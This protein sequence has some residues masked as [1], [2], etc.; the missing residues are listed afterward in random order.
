M[1][2]PPPKV[3][4]TPSASPTPV[5]GSSSF[6]PTP[7]RIADVA[8]PLKR[9]CYASTSRQSR[10]SSSATPDDF[11]TEREA[12][13][14]RMLD[15][16]S[17]LA[18]KY[19]RRI[20]EDDIVDLVTGEIVKDR[21]VLSG[22]T[23]WK[24]GRFADLDD[25][26]G[27]DEEDEDDVDELD[28][29]A[30]SGTTEDPPVHVQ[31][32][33][34][35]PPVRKMDPAD[36]KDLEEFMEAE[37][38]RREEC[39]DDEVSEDGGDLDEQRHAEALFDNGD[40]SDEKDSPFLVKEKASASRSAPPVPHAEVDESDDELGNWDVLDASNIVYV[41]EKTGD[42]QEII[43]ILDTPPPARSPRGKSS[44]PKSKS[45]AP[46]SSKTIG[47]SR[48]HPQ[49]QLQTPPQ[50]R[51]PPSVLPSADDY[52]IP[53]P[54]ASPPSSPTSS[55]YDLYPS[56]PTKPKSKVD[57]DTRTQTRSQSR[58]R[59]SHP[60]SNEPTTSRDEKVVPKLDLANL[61]RGR[62]TTK[63]T[64]RPGLAGSSGAKANGVGKPKTPIVQPAVKQDLEGGG[65][66]KPKANLAS[67]SKQPKASRDA[68][69]R[70]AVRKSPSAL[71]PRQDVDSAYPDPKSRVA[72]TK[73][74]DKHKMEDTAP[75]ARNIKGKCRA[76]DL[77]YDL[78]DDDHWREESNDPIESFA[79]TSLSR[80]EKGQ[81]ASSSFSDSPSKQ[82]S[83]SRRGL[84]LEQQSS[85][86]SPDAVP[87]ST[88][89]RKRRSLSSDN[90]LLME[91]KSSTG[92]THD[93]RPSSSSA[94]RQPEHGQL[95]PPL[96]PKSNLKSRSRTTGSGYESNSNP[97]SEQEL[98]LHRA[99]SR[100]CADLETTAVPVYYPP[101]GPYYPY[102]PYLSSPSQYGADAHGVTPL[103]DPRAQIIISQAMHQAM[104]QLSTLFTAPWMAG[105]PYTP[106]RH[107]SSSRPAPAPGS[108]PYS[109]PTTPH[110]P[111]AYPYI[112]D[113][114]V[115]TGTLPPSSPP[116]SSPPSLASS[117][118]HV[119]SA[120]QTLG[121]RASLVPRS[122][123]RG[124]RVSFRLEEDGEDVQEEVA[125]ADELVDCG[126]SGRS[127]AKR[128]DKG[129]AKMVDTSSDSE[130]AK[131]D[132]RSRTVERAQTPGPPI[133]QA[134][135]SIAE[136]SNAASTPKSKGK[137]RKTK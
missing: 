101:P 58:A 92:V 39:G 84:E 12:S 34:A 94:A 127:S 96:K 20:D 36:A 40:E 37:K 86:P 47:K 35:I 50:S 102:P 11:N 73:S 72:T 14:L 120:N 28:A 17:Q 89:K 98:D 97:E 130:A 24:F 62:S 74:Q 117:P 1:K 113:S 63:S 41:V 133:V 71:S 19:S 88:R 9:Q 57:P 126:D 67:N 85:P 38:R 13:T 76:S 23:S 135:S 59:F 49:L 4:I 53:V 43:E 44:T 5:A 81:M 56:S 68:K 18:E 75:S 124:R 116:D 54:F 6:F 21:G 90:E 103:Q 108:S 83:Q 61:S 3:P 16:W 137:T 69:R 114:G 10:A 128:R 8:P 111:H 77:E 107:P 66:R 125:Q 115:S 123:S 109:Y 82:R 31:G 134:S 78:G 93:A 26:T 22:E 112:F 110:H 87:R 42:S 51:T 32:G 80:P 99:S 27:T 25:S 119:H 55:H 118:T 129:K 30:G 60:R 100:R 52:S 122:R 105:P 79:S 64:P 104:H 29:F 95:S 2:P 131:V 136:P 33:W 106:P 91:Y 46:S 121:R 132:S 48:S 65:E 70:D 7:Y 45:K 15:V